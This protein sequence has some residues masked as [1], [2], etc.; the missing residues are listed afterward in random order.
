MCTPTA[1]HSDTLAR[2]ASHGPLHAG[3]AWSR[4][5]SHPP[6]HVGL[7]ALQKACLDRLKNRPPCVVL[8]CLRSTL[9]DDI[10]REIEVETERHLAK[11]G[12]KVVSAD[13][14]YLTV[15]S[16]NVPNLTLV[17]MPGERQ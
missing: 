11:T 12:G 7:C 14:I 2:A 13:P 3:Q 5:V 6:S 10:T 9:A 1:V 16:V 17:D 4:A 8:P 15:H